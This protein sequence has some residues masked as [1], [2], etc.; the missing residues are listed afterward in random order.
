MSALEPVIG[1]EVH[2]QLA[3]TS[4]LFSACPLEQ[5]A[6]P[7]TRTDPF[8]WGLPG[9]LPVLNAEAV[10][11]AIAL[12]IAT[13]CEVHGDSQFARKHYFYP[14]LPKGYQITQSDRPYATGGRLLVPGMS[15]AEGAPL[16]VR[17]Q[18]IHLEE[19]AGKNLHG[20]HGSGIDY[21]RAGAPLVEIVSEPDLRSAEQAAAYLKEL[22][23]I[24]RATGISAANMEEG[25]LRCDANV[26]LRPRGSDVLGVRCEI[27]NVNSFRFLARAIEAEIR[28]QTDL[29]EAGEPIRRCT[30]GYDG[31]RDRLFV[32]RSKEDAADYR[33]L[34][35][36]DLPPLAIPAAWVAEIRA[37]LPELPARR[38][39]RWC[40]AGIAV[41]DATLLAS[42]RELADY[43]DAALA[44][45]GVARAKRLSGWVTTEL[46][47]RLADEGVAIERCPIAPAAL[48]ELVAL[49]DDGTISG[50]TGKDLFARLWQGEPSPS[51]IVAREGLRQLSDTGAIDAVIAQVLAANPSQL[52]SLRAGKVALRGYFVGQIMKATRGQ[53]NPGLVAQRLDAAIARDDDA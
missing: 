24:I 8:S 9:T 41:D 46:L 31:E 49:V 11:K 50:R 7:N 38:R 16:V 13:D 19:D 21:N 5:G 20:T 15:N 4:K 35:D 18:R 27:K 17:L 34:P 47:G 40:D 51:A 39:A 14:D 33:Y 26:S 3:T 42:E 45:V 48:A 10:R 32:M 43:F 28:R 1:L 6:A 36:P 53:A 29:L 37:T 25:T 22:R 44:A 23:A 2:C 30:L 52:A 12:A